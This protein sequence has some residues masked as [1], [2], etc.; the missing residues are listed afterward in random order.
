MS[1]DWPT[2]A[3]WL[4]PAAAATSAAHSAPAATRPATAGLAVAGVPLV[5]GAVTPCRY[6]LTPAA[7]RARLA[8]FSTFQGERGVHLPPVR[9]LG[10]STAPPPLDAGL[11]VMIGGHN[12]VTFEA[13]RGLPDL[14]RWALLT[15][16]AH[17]DVRPYGPGPPGNG[18]PVRAL[19][20]AGLPAAHVVQ[21]GISQFANSPVHRRWCEE[22][23]IA[24][25]GPG[26]VALVPRLL[27]RLAEVAEHIYVDLDLDVLDRAFAPGCPGSRPGGLT[28]RQVLDAAFAAG[29]HPAVRALD[30]VEV[31][32]DLDVASITVDAAALCL[33][34]AAAGFA[35]R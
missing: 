28:P 2:A 14:S 25:H 18:S 7:V 11:T 16:D 23:G 20:D 26:D 35:T 32:A 10:D 22:Q 19:I 13:L 8:R 5:E 6:D 12:G 33:L 27:D 3:E 17:H 24:I 21:V 29:A 4:A 15:L 30:V 9:D 31:A 1:A 34:N